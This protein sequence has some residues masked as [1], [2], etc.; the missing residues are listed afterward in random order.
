MYTTTV[1]A[2]SL[3]S[4][5]S[6]AELMAEAEFYN[7]D[8]DL[9]DTA[10]AS[11]TTHLSV[12]MAT[13]NNNNN[14]TTFNWTPSLHPSSYIMKRLIQ[15]NCFAKGSYLANA[16]ARWMVAVDNTRASVRAFQTCLRLAEPDDH[17]VVIHVRQHDIV[18]SLPQ[19]YREWY[20]AIT[21]C[22]R[23]YDMLTDPATSNGRSPTSFT[24]LAPCYHDARAIVVSWATKLSIDTLVVGKHRQEDKCLRVKSQHWR[25]F[26]SYINRNKQLRSTRLIQV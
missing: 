19:A 16:N 20:D 24:I 18:Q 12:A 23:Y 15:I 13:T 21:I 4:S 3:L 25:S 9:L 11:S 1:F 2:T 17:I 5:S 22:K 10:P 26:V 14:N 7:G 8:D 6:R